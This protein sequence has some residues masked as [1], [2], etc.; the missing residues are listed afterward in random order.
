M[1]NVSDK[2]CKAIVQKV[3][4]EDSSDS[5]DEE[6]YEP[7][8]FSQSS[9]TV[10]SSSNVADDTDSDALLGTTATD[11]FKTNTNNS[12]N[13]SIASNA[14]TTTTTRRRVTD[15]CQ[16]SDLSM[17]LQQKARN[18]IQNNESIYILHHCQAINNDTDQLFWWIQ[19]PKRKSQ[20]P[21]KVYPC[22]IAHEDEAKLLDLT[23]PPPSATTNDND[24]APATDKSRKRLVKFLGVKLAYAGK[25]SW[26]DSKHL[27]PM[28][29]SN[30]NNKNPAIIS[31]DHMNIFLNTI[32]LQKYYKEN[33]FNLVLEQCCLE[34]IVEKCLRVQCK[35]GNDN[36]NK[37]KANPNQQ[38]QQQQQGPNSDYENDN[39]NE[40][41]TL[42]PDTDMLL[43][44]DSPVFN[45]GTD[46]TAAKLRFASTTTATNSCIGN[47]DN[48][49]DK[50]QPAKRTINVGSTVEYYVPNAVA[51]KENIRKSKVSQV[52]N[53]RN[54]DFVLHLE[55][56]QMLQRDDRVKLLAHMSRGKL[57]TL[58][59]PTFRPVSAYKLQ[60]NN[61]SSND[62]QQQQQQQQQEWVGMKQ[63]RQVREQIQA[64]QLDL[65]NNPE[66]CM[67]VDTFQKGPS[68]KKQRKALKTI[69]TTETSEQKSKQ[70]RQRGRET[71]TLAITT[72]SEPTSVSIDVSATEEQSKPP[73]RRQ[74]QLQPMK[75]YLKDSKAASFG[76]EPKM[77]NNQKTKGIA[78]MTVKHGVDNTECRRI[79]TAKWW[80]QTSSDKLLQLSKGI[81]S[82]QAASIGN[83]AAS[84]SRRMSSRVASKHHMLPEQLQCAAQVRM[85][86]EACVSKS[87]GKLT[88]DDVLSDIVDTAA[89]AAVRGDN[90]GDVLFSLSQLRYFL[91]GDPQM[92]VKTRALS[93]IHMVLDKWLRDSSTDL[94]EEKN[95]DCQQKR[96]AIVEIQKNKKLHTSRASFGNE[97]TVNAKV[98]DGNP[99]PIKK[100]KVKAASKPSATAAARS[101]RASTASG[102][103][104]WGVPK[105]IKP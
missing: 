60:N 31:K 34:G 101:R 44:D 17:Q 3:L 22:R 49:K 58:A 57:N 32:R 16:D 19:Q 28:V 83:S 25:I 75:K 27:V 21:T 73:Q 64:A 9:I 30:N 61:G 40:N 37:T 66:T 74:H 84:S 81:E 79:I 7:V 98:S 87:S 47:N 43:N 100:R 77:N 63:V 15:T 97:N 29:D 46:A 26:E 18:R 105:S 14:M 36:T 96:H 10:S 78:S 24:N 72:R 38:Q 51:S 52:T 59:N 6:M 65:A 70:Q 56:G 71:T 68:S 41:D 54:A 39:D 4:M 33:P 20:K 1:S 50:K 85:R 8:I 42:R 2:S 99:S 94:D 5:S 102:Y 23:P 35:Q 91:V 55:N 62:Q 69:A 103:S 45:S 11:T 104:S 88:V 90:E 93:N 53:H 86:I 13:N 80:N 82:S 67:L 76:S 95:D 92:L 48:G 89:S 12:T